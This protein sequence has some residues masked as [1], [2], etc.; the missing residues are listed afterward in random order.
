[1]SRPLPLHPPGMRLSAFLLC[2]CAC[3]AT[4]P[5]ASEADVSPLR[6]ED[7]AYGRTLRPSADGALQTA[8]L[9]RVVYEGVVS[10][11]L[12]DIRVFDATGRQVPHALRASGRPPA[13]PQTMR[14]P[15]FALPTRAP[16]APESAWGVDAEVGED[17][18]VIRLRAR[19][20]MA[21]PES[22][23]PES[24]ATAYLLDASGAPDAIL[25]LDLELD[26]PPGNFMA[27]LRVDASNDTSVFRPLVDRASIVRLEEQG[28]SIQRLHVDLPR[29]RQKYLRLRWMEDSPRLPIRGVTARLAARAVDMPLE[30]LRLEG[31]PVDGRPGTH[32]FEI[33]GPLPIEHV[34]VLPSDR[35]DLMRV[36]LRGA[37]DREGP[38]RLR[39]AGL[40]HR[41][42]GGLSPISGAP[43]QNDPIPWTHWPDRFIEVVVS[44]QGG[45]REA[46]APQLEVA[47][48]PHQLLFV[49]RGPGPYRLAW[50]RADAPDRAFDAPRLLERTRTPLRELPAASAQ[51]GEPAPLGD[52]SVLEPAPRSVPPRTV[53]LWILLVLVVVAVAGMSLRLIGEIKA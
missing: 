8:L 30:R 35:N 12:H 42:E 49:T 4:K 9:D 13:A 20:E 19:A 52:A 41:F 36:E 18:A 5:A 16:A 26:A 15:V 53:A 40:I 3:I 29:A 45:A 17:G 25:R 48:A 1:M 32:R 47:W 7:F 44:P 39:W 50:G 2:L 10:E 38:Y 11:A 23:A 51:M 22:A 43:L 31:E 37:R 21:A 24:G 28:H 46:S 34:Q 14:L 33:G 6:P 27:I